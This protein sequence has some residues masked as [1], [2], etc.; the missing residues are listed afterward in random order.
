MATKAELQEQ[1]KAQGVK[2]NS[3]TTKAELEDKL[4]QGPAIVDAGGK[5]SEPTAETD[6]VETVKVN[7]NENGEAT[8]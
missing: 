2:F 3:K 5:A 1:A 6:N 8:N 4:S 7:E